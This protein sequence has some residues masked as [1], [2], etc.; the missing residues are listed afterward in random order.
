[1]QLTKNVCVCVPVSVCAGGWEERGTASSKPAWHEN[2]PLCIVWTGKLGLH[3]KGCYVLF[4]AGDSLS[5]VIEVPA[6]ILDK[7][8]QRDVCA[9]SLFPS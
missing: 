2:K 5:Y 3:C 6:V 8:S 9:C 1:M 4:N 7:C